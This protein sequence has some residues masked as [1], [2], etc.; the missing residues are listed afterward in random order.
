[1]HIRLAPQY[2][3]IA[4]KRIGGN[5]N[6]SQAVSSSSAEVLDT[7]I[8][9]QEAVSFPS[10]VVAVIVAEPSV[11]TVTSPDELTTATS[12][13]SLDHST[14]L[15]VAL[16][17]T[18]LTVNVSVVPTLSVSFSCDSVNPLTGDRSTALLSRTSR[19][20]AKQRWLVHKTTHNRLS[21]NVCTK[22]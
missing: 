22:K 9:L 8:T 7:T 19:I 13:L 20:D 14:S 5:Q 2:R 21:T 3:Q 10:A 6:I 18:M 15:F 4:I 17:D 11:L 12:G 1:M 16:S